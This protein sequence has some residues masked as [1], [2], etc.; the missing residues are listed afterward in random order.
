MLS[1]ALDKIHIRD[2]RIN[3]IIGVRPEERKTGQEILLNICL[4]TDTSSAGETDDLSATIDYDVLCNQIVDKT[5][6]WSFNLIESL[7]E[8][9]AGELLRIEAVQACNVGVE[10][11]GALS[12]ARSAAVEIFR[13]R[14]P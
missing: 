2:L 4:F 6:S 7:A 1:E 13:K 5:L 8:N 9:I 10:K 12:C 11:I 14:K 3:T